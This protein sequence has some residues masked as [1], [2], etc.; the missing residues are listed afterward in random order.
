MTAT[1]RY[2]TGR[3][4]EA[5]KER[6]M[7]VASMDEYSKFGAVF[8]RLSFGK[9]ISL[10]RLTDYQVAVIAVDP[11]DE[12]YRDMAETGTLLKRDGKRTDGHTLASQIGLA[13]AMRKYDLR[14]VISFHSRKSRARKFAADMPE[15]IDWMPKQERPSGSLWTGVATG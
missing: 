2:Y 7:E 15:V 13:K 1:P 14:R 3:V 6:E 10:G 11:A 12:T 5:S 8:H 4:I 9:A